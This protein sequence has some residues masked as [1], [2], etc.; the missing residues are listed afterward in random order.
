MNF[1]VGGLSGFSACSGQHT[2]RQT[3]LF[4]VLQNHW[5]KNACTKLGS[6]GREGERHIKTERERER[7]RE[8][9]KKER[10]RDVITLQ[11]WT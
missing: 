10:E 3:S 4:C 2:P 5:Q 8:R 6:S 9:K 1:K 11:P 7:E